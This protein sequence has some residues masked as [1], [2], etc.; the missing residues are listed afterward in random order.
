MKKLFTHKTIFQNFAR[1]DSIRMYQVLCILLMFITGSVT[2]AQLGSGWAEYSPTKKIHLDNEAGLQTYNWTSYK[3][4]CSPVCA[5]YSYDSNNDTETFRLF[6][7]RTN[8]SEIRL[9][10]EYSTGSR[11]FE[12]Y[13]TFYAPLNDESLMQIFGSVSGATQMMIRGYAADGGS[14]TGAGKTLATN[15]YGKEVKVN[16]IHLQD[17]VGNKIQIYIDDVKMAEIEDNEAVTN[18]HKYGNYGTLRTDEA[19][20]KWRRA[21]FFRDG[22][23]PGTVPPPPPAGNPFDI[24]DNGGFLSSQYN[25][26]R[27]DEN[28]PK[29][30]DN[31][32]NTKYYQNGK[33]AL[34]V[35]YKSTTPAV[36]TRYAITSAND[37]EERDPKDWT[38]L[39]SDNGST[40]TTLDRRTGEDFPTRFLTRAFLINNQ[41]PFVFYRL[42]ITSNGNNNNTQFAEW[43]LYQTKQQSI[44]FS[45]IPD[46]T[47]G[48]EPFELNASSDSELPVGFE[49]VSGP[50][51]LNDEVLTITGAGTVIVKASQAGDENYFPA[52]AEQSFVVNKASQ[53]ISFTSVS[54]KNKNE[55]VELAA[56]S[57]AGLPITFTIISGSGSITGNTLSFT[58]EGNIIVQAEQPGDGNYLPAENVMQAVLVFADDVKKD[59][60]K[61][62]VYPNPTQGQLK[63][64]LESKQDK[65]Y[66]FIIYDDKGT[67][68]V[69]SVLQKSNK[70]YEI[71]FDLAQ[72]RNGFYYLYISDG[73]DIIVRIIIKQ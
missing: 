59:G 4:V 35:Q 73:T 29:L 20:V 33:K 44:S 17:D 69:S 45:E 52:S 57:S 53:T 55:T 43:E 40:W 68:V 7:N 42:N 61:I 54:P 23:A 62:K 38:L 9:Q 47:F 30:I 24:T 31:N 36:V 14:M 60:I 65:D 49:I 39:G 12:G 63:V 3:S 71:D 15:V 8:R 21:R 22:Y 64:K 25:S 26:N 28:Y 72:S 66:T 32:I 27:P 37:V 19:I 18:Y 6:D 16:V 50:A 2:H 1:P 10:N 13:V 41:Q 34:W 70:K 5:D 48:D 11:Q 46:K 51:I 56:V 58:G 67:P